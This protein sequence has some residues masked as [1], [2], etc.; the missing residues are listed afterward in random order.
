M[1]LIRRLVAN[2]LLAAGSQN[3]VLPGGTQ[4]EL[5]LEVRRLLSAV[6]LPRPSLFDLRSLL[7][8]L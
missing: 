5:G 7:L 4:Q 2:P 8:C 3:C 6:S 1:V